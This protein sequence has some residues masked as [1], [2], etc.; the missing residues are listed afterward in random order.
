MESNAALPPIPIF[1]YPLPFRAR[2]AR[3]SRSRFRS[4]MSS[5]R[6]RAQMSP[7]RRRVLSLQV[8]PPPAAP[9]AAPAAPARRATA[10]ARP[11]RPA[12]DRRPRARPASHRPPPA[13]RARRRPPPARRYV[14][15]GDTKEIMKILSPDHHFTTS[16]STLDGVRDERS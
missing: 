15:C 9:P 14:T 7:A 1:L 2:H 11:P 8:P 4:N 16:D 3:T 12:A 13:R 10:A 5:R 6:T